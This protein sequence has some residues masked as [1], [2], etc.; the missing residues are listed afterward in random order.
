MEPAQVKRR[1]YDSSGRRSASRE[2]RN[3]ILECARAVIVDRGYRATTI[4]QIAEL[5]NVNADTIYELVGR[6]PVI[7]RELI[8]RAISGEDRA[9]AAEEREYVRNLRAEPDPVA[10][11]RIY[12]AAV[13]AIQP[14]LA[15]L[16]L[17]LSDAASTDREARAVW[18]EIS[19][20]RYRNMRKLARN[21]ESTGRMRGDVSIS[22]A[23]DVLWATNS[24]EFY[25]QLVVARG[26]SSRRFSS[27]LA[28]TWCR[29]LLTA[30]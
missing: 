4:A 14:R 27:W 2:T 7:L 5:A 18:D 30:H 15:P 24:S 22:Q 19:A 25:V 23:A 13:A 28:E 10:K 1:P 9:V 11:L 20:R 21:L 8:E 3:R 6:K 16:F 26:W 12:A 29:L 17:A